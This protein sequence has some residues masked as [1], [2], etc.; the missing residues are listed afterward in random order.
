MSLMVS[1]NDKV[2]YLTLQKVYTLHVSESCVRNVPDVI[3]SH[4]LFIFMCVRSS[5]HDV[6]MHF[7]RFLCDCIRKNRRD[8]SIRKESHDKQTFEASCS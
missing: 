6:E 3:F 2:S 8:F 5:W 1:E 7:L 4:V